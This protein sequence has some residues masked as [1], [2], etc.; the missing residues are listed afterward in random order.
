MSGPPPV[1]PIPLPA[2]LT[3][4]PAAAPVPAPAPAA[5]PAAPA[6]VELRYNDGVTVKGTQE[7]VDKTKAALDKIK[8]TATGASLLDSLAASGQMTTIVHTA[9][10]NSQRPEQWSKGLAAGTEFKFTLADGTERTI[11]GVGGGSG[12]TVSFNPDKVQIGN[13]SE[14]W[15]TRPPEIG[16][17]HELIH[18]DD[19][20]HGNL[21]PTK[22]AGSTVMNAERQAVGLPPFTDKQHTENKLRAEWD[23]PQPARPRY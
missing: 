4:A 16:L 22:P 5:P 14:D 18:A 21:D 1:P 17:A 12:S 15:M 10:G 7:F 23:P 11:T 20:A 19:A 13:G 3:A 8:T 9:K 6:V 2:W